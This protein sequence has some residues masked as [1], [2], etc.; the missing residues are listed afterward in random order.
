MNEKPNAAKPKFRR[1][2]YQ[3]SLRTLLIVVAL[4]SLPFAYVAHEARIVRERNAWLR[5]KTPHFY[6]L[7]GLPSTFATGDR[8]RSPSLVRCWLGDESHDGVIVSPSSP[9]SEKRLAAELFPEADVLEVQQ[10]GLD[11]P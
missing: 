4:L 10:V 7:F 3:Y 2:W 8:S 1:R 6:S 9:L 5:A 11:T